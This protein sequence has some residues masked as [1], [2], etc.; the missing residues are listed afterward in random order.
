M[1]AHIKSH[2]ENAPPISPP[3]SST[4]SESSCSSSS[5]DK[6]NKDSPIH[7]DTMNYESSGIYC[8]IRDRVTPLPYFRQPSPQSGVELL[9]AAAATVTERV[10][11]DHLQSPVDEV[12]NLISRPQNIVNLRHPAY[13]T[14]ESHPLNTLNA[15][16]ALRQVEAALGDLPSEDEPMLTPPSSNPVSPAPSVSPDPEL[17]LPP[18]K[19]SKMIAKSMESVKDLSPVRYNSVIQYARAS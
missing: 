1:E 14:Y 5:S 9:A 17:S 18:R 3:S 19:R 12:V 6:E 2:S 7:Q 11:N 16:D 10:Y 13:Y 8:I 4:Q 15:G